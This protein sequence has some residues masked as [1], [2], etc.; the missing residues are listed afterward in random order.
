MYQTPVKKSTTPV[1]TLTEQS[2]PKKILDPEPADS[3]D[4]LLDPAEFENVTPVEESA[5]VMDVVDELLENVRSKRSSNTGSVRSRISVTSD[6]KSVASVRQAP[7]RPSIGKLTTTSMPPPPPPTPATPAKENLES[8]S[9]GRPSPRR[10]PI[11]TAK[12]VAQP[13]VIS[14]D[15]DEGTEASNPSTPVSNAKR[16]RDDF[17]DEADDILRSLEK[18]PRR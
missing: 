1:K 7:S 9:M 3:Q 15:E 8:T 4:P 18:R 5:H 2:T 14:D 13:V 17:G 6:R 16:K 10:T 11:R 12:V